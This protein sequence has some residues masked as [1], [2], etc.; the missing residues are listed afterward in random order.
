MKSKRLFALLLSVLM[1][2]AMLS[3]CGSQGE[4]EPAPSGNDTTEEKVAVTVTV[5]GPQ[6]DQAADTGSWLQKECEAFAAEHPEWDI[7][8]V[9]GVCSEG[10]A[11]TNVTTDPSAAADVYMFAN[12]QIPDLVKAGAIAE[13]GG[14]TVENMKANNSETTVNTVTYD[15]SVYGFPFTG[16]TWFMFYDK[17]V[18][19][20][21]DVKSLDAML[22]KAPVAFPLSNSW[23]LASFYV[24]NGCTLFG[25]SG[26]DEA[27]GIDFSGDKAVAVTEY[28]VGLV[29]NANFKNGDV[30]SASDVKAFFSGTWDYDKAVDAYGENLGICPAPSITVNGELKQMK[31]FAG[32]KAIGVNPATSLYK[33]H[34]EIAVA[35]AAYL[36]GTSAQK[37]HYDLRNTIP[38]DLN[39]S[40]PS[41]A[42]AQA[43]MDTMAYASIVQPVVA[44]MGQYWTPA[45]S[46]GEELVAGT[47][48]LANAAEKTEAMNDA[49]NSTAVS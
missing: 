26:S 27:A 1:V 15:G 13:L 20:E 22:E 29:N 10:D 3:G 17:S 2:M 19:T 42:L 5:W 39:V 18:F 21:E 28:L 49:M 16:N 12:D 32:S 34:P 7:T 35:L 11:K 24:A 45:Q 36:G 44:S 43:Q 23:Y 14:T 47:V 37:D 40:V 6:E 8:F 41:D 38:T 33:E 25:T 48:T 4:T 9:Y 46:M 31:S 30:G